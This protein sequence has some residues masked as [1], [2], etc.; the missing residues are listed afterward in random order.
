M[1]H[2]SWGVLIQAYNPKRPFLLIKNASIYYH[3]ENLYNKVTVIFSISETNK[4]KQVTKLKKIVAQLRMAKK[5]YYSSYFHL[6]IYITLCPPQLA[7]HYK[8]K[9]KEKSHT[10]SWHEPA[11]A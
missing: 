4:K 6:P 8:K 1:F 2:V 3:L 7:R 5:K 9:W 11:K 10:A